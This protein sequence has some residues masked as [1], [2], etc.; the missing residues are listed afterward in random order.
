M[1]VGRAGRG[2][3]ESTIGTRRLRDPRQLVRRRRL[4]AVERARCWRV[5]CR[6][7]RPRWAGGAAL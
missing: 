3:A 1:R 2:R 6:E 4:A 5:P 7:M